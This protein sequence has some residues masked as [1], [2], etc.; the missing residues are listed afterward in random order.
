[1]RIQTPIGEINNG[2]LSFTLPN[3]S[4][5]AGNG[6][7]LAE[8]F[9]FNRLAGDTK[10]DGARTS[11]VT[12]NTMEVAIP[13]DAK[14]L[15]GVIG[16][17]YEG[18]EYWLS[19]DSETTFTWPMYVNKPGTLKGEFNSTVVYTYTYNGNLYT[20]TDNINDT[21]NCTFT[22]GWNI[23]YVTDSGSLPGPKPGVSTTNTFTRNI[24]TNPPANAANMRWIARDY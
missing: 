15:E 19:Y 20:N 24:S 13:Q 9:N 11:T 5:Y 12:K 1:V 23:I 8:E 7:L 2:K 3:V 4:A 17:S 18:E 16:F 10:T 22:A 14:M 6:Y 21:Y